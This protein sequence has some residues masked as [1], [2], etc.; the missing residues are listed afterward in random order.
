MLEALQNAF[1]LPDLRRK[2]LFT[3]M[4]LVIFRLA[5]HI[6]VPGV[7]IEAL[8]QLFQQNQLLGFLNLLSGGA[9]ENFSVVAMGVYPFITASIILQLLQPLVPQLEELSKEGE[10]GRQKLTSPY[11]HEV[12]RPLRLVYAGLMAGKEERPVAGEQVAAGDI[13]DMVNVPI[14][15]PRPTF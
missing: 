6:P 15:I 11:I 12:S 8:R 9:L 10:A 13:G 3:F 5:A 7:N 1:R 4:I 14:P 2:I